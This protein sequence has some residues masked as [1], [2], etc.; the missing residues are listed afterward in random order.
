MAVNVETLEKLGRKIAVFLP[1]DDVQ[2]EMMVRLR[3]LSKNVKMPGFR[4]GKIPMNVMVQQYGYSVEQEVLKEKLGEAFFK[5][6]QEAD[7]KVAGAPSFKQ[8]SEDA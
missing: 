4:P 2:K 1:V 6:I 3:R 7:L 8:K 5:L